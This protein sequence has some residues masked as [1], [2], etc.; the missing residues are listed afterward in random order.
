[1]KRLLLIIA[2]LTA[3]ACSAPDAD[4][5][6]E[7]A[8]KVAM[9]QAM[10]DAYEAEKALEAKNVALYDKMDLEAFTA[11][12]MET[13]KQIHSDDVIV[14][15]PDGSVT[16]GMTPAHE[17]EL[18]WLFNTFPDIEINEH[19]IKFGSGDWTA[20]MSVTTGTFSAPMKLASGEVIEPTGKSFKIRI[21]TLVRWKDGRI[22]EEYLFW[23]NLDWNR[24]I[25]IAK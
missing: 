5:S 14:Y 9:L 16:R 15:N 6:A 20:G 22:A 11:H 3:S 4:R 1:M 2:M 19:P 18:Q 24:Q 25:G 13:I 10:V 23:D 8:E 17:A 7:L 12:D 21:V